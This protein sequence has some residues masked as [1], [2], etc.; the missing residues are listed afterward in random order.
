MSAHTATPPSS[1]AG[2]TAHAGTST[3]SGSNTPAGRYSDTRSLILNVNL[4]GFGQRPASWRTQDVT[5]TEVLD[6]PFW[7]NLGRVAERGLLDSVFFADNPS[8]GNPNLRPLGLVEPFVILQTIAAATEH[9]GLVGTASTSYND[10]VELAER[11]LSLDTISG[12]RLAWNA[13]TTYNPAVSGNFGVESNAPRDERYR[14]AAE[15]VE[16]VVALW[17]SAATGVPV[18]HDGEFFTEHRRLHVPPSAQGHPVIFQA[19]GSPQ[20][21]ELASRVAEGVFAVELLIDPAIEH[22]RQVTEGTR[23]FGRTPADVSIIP[24]LSLVIGSTEEEAWRH[25]DAQEALA[26]E[27]YTRGAL[28]GFLG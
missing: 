1:P 12:G 19:G 27:G 18:Q 11:L 23:R 28:G 5:G 22:Y 26:P 9:L 21:R 25:F 24:G 20:G 8:L 15:F 14:R 10:P 16:L 6:A 17:Q 7:E 13:V 3:S 2:L 4:Q